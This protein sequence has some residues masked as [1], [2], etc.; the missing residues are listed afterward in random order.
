MSLRLHDF[1]LS[2]HSYRIR[3]FLSLLDLSHTVMPVNLLAGTHKTPEFLGLNPFGQVPVLEDG[4]FVIADSNAILVYLAERY[5]P[6]SWYPRSP[7][8]KAVIQRWLSV[9]AGQLAFYPAAARRANMFAQ[10]L[11]GALI[12]HAHD[13]FRVI[14]ATLSKTP[15]LTGENATIADLAIYS[16]TAIAPEGNV[17]L[18]GYPNIRAWLGRIEALPGFVPMPRSKVGLSA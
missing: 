17:S 6:E 14:D 2:G 4:E 11:D 18:D 12:T 13:L 5:A 1:A 3:L 15:F 16:Y 7:A 10:P 9:A 8:E